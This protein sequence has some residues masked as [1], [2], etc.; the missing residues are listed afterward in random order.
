L[1]PG[2][3]V[4]L[5]ILTFDRPAYLAEC[6]ASV[7]R[8]TLA[9]FRLVVLDNASTADYSGVLDRFGGLPMHYIRNE[10]NIGGA[11]NFWKAMQCYSDSKYLVIFHDDDMMHPKMLEWQLG[12]L[13]SDPEIQFVSTEYVA[14]EDVDAPPRAIWDRVN[15][16]IDVYNKQ[17]DL[18]RSF[19]GGG[20]LCYGSTMYRS[21]ALER[22]R[23]DGYEQFGIVGD[24]PFLL[25]VARPGKSALIR[26]PLVLYRRHS[27]Q[28]TETGSLTVHNL[29][30]LLRTY[31]AALPRHWSRTDQQLFYGYARDYLTRY[32]YARLAPEERI[33]A[34]RFFL[35]C[36]RN[37]VLRLRDI[38]PTGLAIMLRADGMRA[39][40]AAID[41][42]R[43]VKRRFLP[44]PTR[45][46]GNEM[47]SSGERG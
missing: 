24:R 13:E 47:P 22:I 31:R 9:G 25:D 30:E 40:P 37:R 33:G 3:K 11:G 44:R 36:I 27:G 10:T 18:V 14:F 5:A 4:T 6:L 15:F 38:R 41:A 1:G 43:A 8:Q 12:V 42:A 21:S 45:A 7:G 39:L 32:G 35:K 26:A 19:L 23:L 29:I 17:S 20:G 46:E 28:D 16:E 34:T 2:S